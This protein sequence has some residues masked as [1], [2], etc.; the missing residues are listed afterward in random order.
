MEDL[1]SVAGTTLLVKD[2]DGKPDKR[3]IL[4]LAKGPDVLSPTPAFPTQLVRAE[5]SITPTQGA[6]E[7]ISAPT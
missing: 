6:S 4:L 2:R 3:K 7:N 1:F 5:S